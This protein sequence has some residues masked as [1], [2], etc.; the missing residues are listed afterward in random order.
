MLNGS[1]KDMNVQS[2][3]GGPS[4]FQI[5]SSS[6]AC[7]G[8]RAYLQLLMLSHTIHIGSIASRTSR[9]CNRTVDIEVDKFDGR[10]VGSAILAFHH[11]VVQEL[12]AMF[13]QERQTARSSNAPRTCRGRPDGNDETIRASGCKEHRTDR[14]PPRGSRAQ[15]LGFKELFSPQATKARPSTRL[16]CKTPRAHAKGK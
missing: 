2:C 10:H 9:A 7:P 3:A 16:T 11:L 15:M 4:Q 13:S 12:N 5:P 8:G 6:L 1:E 14:V